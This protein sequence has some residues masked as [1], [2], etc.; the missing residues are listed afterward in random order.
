MNR[1]PRLTSLFRPRRSSR[2]NKL[3]STQAHVLKQNLRAILLS[4]E[5][6]LGK[7]LMTSAEKPTA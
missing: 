5:H 2:K 3:D 7:E 6:L 1:L 4:K